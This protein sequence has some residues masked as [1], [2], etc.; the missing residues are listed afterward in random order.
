MRVEFGDV[1]SV[2]PQDHGEVFTVLNQNRRETKNG[3]IL[4]KPDNA[5][6][7][8]IAFKMNDDNKRAQDFNIVTGI[9]SKGL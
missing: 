1:R 8:R 2:G 4:L 3:G 9:A 6:G 5:N 7:Q